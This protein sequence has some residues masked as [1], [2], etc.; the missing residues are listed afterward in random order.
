VFLE[1]ISQVPIVLLKEKEK[2]FLPV[3]VQLGRERDVEG[4]VTG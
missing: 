1:T 4:V 3:A 2:E